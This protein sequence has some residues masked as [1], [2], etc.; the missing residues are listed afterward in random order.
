MSDKVIKLDERRDESPLD[1][2]DKSLPPGEPN[3]QIRAIFEMPDPPGFLQQLD[4]QVFYQ[5]IKS[6]GWSDSYDLVQYA[7]PRQIQNFIDFDCWTRDRLIPEK[8]EKWLTALVT[9]AGDEKLRDVARNL[10]EEMLA[11]FFKHNLV[12]VEEMED[13]EIPNHLEGNVATSPDNVYALVYPED[14]DKAALLRLL[15][16]RL[17]A[18]DRVMAWTLL[19]AARW[20]L[21]SEMEEYAYKWRNSRLEEYGFVSRDE[22]VEVY[23]Y[24]NPREY[25]DKIEA[26]PPGERVDTVVPDSLDLPAVLE[27]EL[28]DEFWAFQALSEVDDPEDVRRIIHQIQSVTNRAMIADGIE[29]GEV[30]SG[31]EVIRR[32]LGYLSLGL[33][34]LSRGTLEVGADRLRDLPVKRVFQ[35]GF[36]LARKLQSNIERLSHR[37]ALTIVEGDR[38]SLLNNDER[39]LAEALT[40][41]RPVYAEDEV[42]FDIFKRQEQLDSAAFRIGQIAFKQLWLFAL[43]QL[44]VSD[45]AEL[46]YGD[47]TLND[48]TSVTFDSLFATWLAN[49]LIAEEPELRPLTGPEIQKLAVVVQDEPWETENA[50]FAPLLDAP[51]RGVPETSKRLFTRWVFEVID[52]LADELGQVKMVENPGIYA[53]VLLVTNDE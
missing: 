13:G 3:E 50:F 46:I 9:E 42:T 37:P 52:D 12:A 44:S 45:V 34:F 31:R 7:K 8:M 40:R 30:E 53:D 27:D 22:A 32:S 19:E 24:I 25:R 14:E 38:Y 23:S 33:E 41:P 48:P 35:V 4:S 39:A 2:V 49:F 51:E 36:S 43:S 20:E 11:I 17:Y 47:E 6:A 1:H 28:D 18:V 29:P 15:I 10:D 26:K 21:M 5:L 16:D